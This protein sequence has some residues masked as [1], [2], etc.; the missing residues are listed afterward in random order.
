MS[1]DSTRELLHASSEGRR[2][3]YAK[4]RYLAGSWEC[5]FVLFLAEEGVLSL[6]E[7]STKMVMKK[8]LPTYLSERSFLYYFDED[9][10][11]YLSRS[12]KQVSND[13]FD[14]NYSSL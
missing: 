9:V 3:P 14:I 8:D 11:S 13:Y 10:S 2:R 6:V 1:V 4:Y 5:R 12:W 7:D